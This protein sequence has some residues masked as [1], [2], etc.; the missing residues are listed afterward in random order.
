M[1]IPGLLT[2]RTVVP[3]VAPTIEVPR[4]MLL[5]KRFEFESHA[6]K[7]LADAVAGTAVTP[8]PP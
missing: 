1:I 7:L 5:A 3:P 2:V 8:V 6:A 4:A